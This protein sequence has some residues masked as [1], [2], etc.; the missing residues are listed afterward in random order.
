MIGNAEPSEPRYEHNR[1]PKPTDT[2]RLVHNLI[3]GGLKGNVQV[4]SLAPTS[5]SVIPVSKGRHHA[6][7]AEILKFNLTHNRIF[8]HCIRRKGSNIRVNIHPRI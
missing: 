8:G 6:A 1:D 7:R 5:G 4:L 2:S 3:S